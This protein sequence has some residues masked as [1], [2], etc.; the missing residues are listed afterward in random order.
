M[1]KSTLRR[2]RTRRL[3][4][5]G[6]VACAQLLRFN[7]TLM[8]L[9]HRIVAEA[10]AIDQA[11]RERLTAPHDPLSDYELEAC[12]AYWLCQEDADYR[13]QAV[14]LLAR[15]SYNVKNMAADPRW[16]AL[17]CLADGENHNEFAFFE[18]PWQDQF[19]CWLY[20]DLY[21]HEY[22]ETPQN[23]RL[24]WADVLRIGSVS[25]SLEVRQQ[26]FPTWDR[27]TG[28]WSDLPPGFQGVSR[29]MM[30]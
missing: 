28:D 3:E 22:G 24:D 29:F 25:W 6:A 15:R 12:V 19:H 26:Y 8:A 17:A 16:G 20:H 4:R 7:Q 11:L 30:I 18:H 2:H 23:Q 5:L 10:R 21:D 14:N 1:A 27:K 13:E 9:E